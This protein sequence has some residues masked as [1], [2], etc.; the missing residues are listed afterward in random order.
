[1]TETKQATG[2]K[3]SQELQIGGKKKTRNKEPLIRV[4]IQ[5]YPK[6]PDCFP[7]GKKAVSKHSFQAQA[8]KWCREE[9][10]KFKWDHGACPH[11][12]SKKE[13]NLGK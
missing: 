12:E 11:L 2:T 5:S 9:S 13:S 7:L 1:M 3:G 10:E 6:V 8:G 4:V